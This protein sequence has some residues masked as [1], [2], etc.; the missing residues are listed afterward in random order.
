MEALVRGVPAFAGTAR[1]SG[2]QQ[3]RSYL[4]GVLHFPVGVGGREDFVRADAIGGR[5]SRPV[6]QIFCVSWLYFDHFGFEAAILRKHHFFL[7]AFGFGHL[8]LKQLV[9]AVAG[10][11]CAEVCLNSAQSLLLLSLHALLLHHYV[12]DLR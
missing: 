7:T 8:L 4:S 12:S 9:D 1:E 2:R 5:A 10:G 3:L 11:L 6:I